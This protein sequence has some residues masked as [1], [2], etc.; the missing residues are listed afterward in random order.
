MQRQS[1][2]SNLQGP[3]SSKAC[4]LPLR[5]R[6]YPSPLYNRNDTAQT[7]MHPSNVTQCA[8]STVVMLA[9][10]VAGLVVLGLDEVAHVLGLL[11]SVV[12]VAVVVVLGTDVLHLVDVAALGA[13]F[14]RAVAGD[15]HV[16]SSISK[17][18]SLQ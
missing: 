15:L 14:D 5:D 8:L 4:K 6:S 18:A 3:S 11:V 2:T 13:S 16:P 7:S 17:D 10:V 9:S 12:V 1:T